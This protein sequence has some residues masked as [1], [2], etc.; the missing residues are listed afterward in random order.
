MT[1]P[2]GSNFVVTLDTMN[3]IV[4]LLICL[5][6]STMAFMKA[7]RSSSF[8]SLR[9]RGESPLQPRASRLNLMRGLLQGGAALVTGL[10]VSQ[11]IPRPIS[12]NAEYPILADDSTMN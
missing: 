9:A 11:N 7:G 8:T 6:V 1:W 5:L 10:V 2:E 4:L 3:V 12:A